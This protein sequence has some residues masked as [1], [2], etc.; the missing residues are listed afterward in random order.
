MVSELSNGINE[1]LELGNLLQIPIYPTWNALD[2]TDYKYYAGRIGTYGGSGRNFG[3]QNSDL[4]ISV[5]LRISGE[6]L[7]NVKTFARAKKYLVDIINQI[8]K[9]I[10]NKSN[11]MR[12]YIAM[13]KFF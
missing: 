5:G 12:I 10:F 11:L 13:P 2:I 4:I 3:I 9:K 7:G 8:L 6:L 1:L